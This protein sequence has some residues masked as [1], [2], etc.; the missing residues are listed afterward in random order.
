MYCYLCIS[1]VARESPPSRL[2][3][4]TFYFL[5]SLPIIFCLPN[6]SA[7]AWLTRSFS[8]LVSLSLFESSDL[9]LLFVP[10]RPLRPRLFPPC[11][12]LPSLLALAPWLDSSYMGN[13]QSPVEPDTSKSSSS[14]S[15]LLLQFLSSL[16]PLRCHL[17]RSVMHFHFQKCSQ[18]TFQGGL[19]S[20]T[21]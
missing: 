18:I 13:I 15:L 19:G 17:L 14:S 7:P 6:L 3:I 21:Q 4:V 5:S 2:L 12:L 16:S 20:G 9:W 1:I 8:V 11:L 10:C